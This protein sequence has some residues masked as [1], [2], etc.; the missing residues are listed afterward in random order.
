MLTLISPSKINLF[1]Q[2]VGRRPDGYHDLASLFQTV[3][4]FDTLHLSLCKQDEL[5]CTSRY[6][7]IDHTN[8]VLKA[9]EC[10]RKH[11]GLRVG[12]HA[13]LVKRIPHRAGLGGG[14]SNAATTL[15]GLNQLCGKP[16]TEEQLML[17]ATELGSDVPFF[18]SKGT[19]YCTG[20]GE[21][22]RPIPLK[23]SQKLWIVKPNRGLSTPKVF[24]QV[25]LNL[26]Q[27]RNPE[28]SLH[29]FQTGIFDCYN[30]LET[31]AYKVYPKLLDL[32]TT[33]LNAGFSSVSMTGSGSAFFC[34][35]DVQPPKIP[36]T[37][38]FECSFIT[39]EEGWY[40]SEK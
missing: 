12:V 34:L 15:W 11:T 2:V 32:K 40:E 27:N 38:C 6:I 18:L 7:P 28:N 22:I 37:R 10:F 21:K 5:S 31:A 20:R 25:D 33:L 13:H 16:A 24:S 8:L 29:R 1:L 39:R 4:F 17:W 26:L 9:A 30:D 3:S 23:Y 36:K 19:S 14:S 35:G